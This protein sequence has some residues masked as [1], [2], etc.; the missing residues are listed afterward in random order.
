MIVLNYIYGQ[1]STLQIVAGM[2]MQGDCGNIHSLREKKKGKWLT[3]TN[4][5]YNSV[6]GE[7]VQFHKKK[8]SIAASWCL[9]PQ[10]GTDRQGTKR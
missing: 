3:Y 4:I 9:V 5:P 1:T 7:G 6:V 8:K 10:H 2:Y